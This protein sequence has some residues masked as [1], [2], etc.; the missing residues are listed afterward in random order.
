MLMR[1][2]NSGNTPPLLFGL[3][4]CTSIFEIILAVSQKTG[5]Q[6]SSGLSKTT[7]GHIIKW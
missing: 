7:L 1:M 2:C 6:F 4:T 3:K 5:D